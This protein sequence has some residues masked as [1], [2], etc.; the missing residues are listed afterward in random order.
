[1]TASLTIAAAALLGVFASG[2]CLLM[3]GGISAALGSAT[4]R[5]A[6][7]RPRHALMLGYQ[8][9]RLASYTLV[10]FAAGWLGHMA[11]SWLQIDAVTVGLRVVAGLVMLLSAGALLGW[12]RNP[13]VAIGRPLW[14]RLS[15]LGRYLLPVN[16]LPRAIGF[17][18][19][20]GWMPCGFIY[21]VVLV[22]ALTADPRES[23]LALLAFGVGTLPAM[24]SIGI[25][26]QRVSGFLSRPAVRRGGGMAL[27]VLAMV[28]MSGPWLVHAFPALHATLPFDC[29]TV[30]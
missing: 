29:T 10:G 5:G 7:G 25:A 4:A 6:D 3:C 17:G 16:N 21:N 8:I 9:G 13:A 30:H 12:L 2:H 14:R 1:M 24:L 28:T 18:M 27:I 26:G 20:W 23:A 19:L 22:A 15:A 11:I